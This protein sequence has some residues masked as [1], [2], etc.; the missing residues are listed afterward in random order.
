[1]EHT[2]VI[3]LILELWLFK[4]KPA[5]ELWAF[6]FSL[7]LGSHKHQPTS[8]HFPSANVQVMV[9]MLPRCCEGSHRGWCQLVWKGILS[10]DVPGVRAPSSGPQLMLGPKKTSLPSGL[11]VSPGGPGWAERTRRGTPPPTVLSFPQN[12]VG[13]L[14]DVLCQPRHLSLSAGPTKGTPLGA[15]LP[16]PVPRL[17]VTQSMKNLLKTVHTDCPKL[18]LPRSPL[19]PLVHKLRKCTF[20]PNLE[21][22]RK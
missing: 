11:Y 8:L 13:D 19:L 6:L 21:R 14:A 12:S 18:L 20:L 10:R 22:I 9:G 7:S 2:G 5:W 1:M 17:F 15:P 4:E 3:N 16:L